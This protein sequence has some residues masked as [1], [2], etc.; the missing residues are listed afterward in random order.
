V[1]IGRS[2]FWVEVALLAVAWPVGKPGSC[3]GAQLARVI[4]KNPVFRNGRAVIRTVTS[5]RD[6]TSFADLDNVYPTQMA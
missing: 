6:W 5:S 4:E 2:P 3:R 1:R